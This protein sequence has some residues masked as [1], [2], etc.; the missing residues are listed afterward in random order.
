MQR[1]NLNM[2]PSKKSYASIVA[3]DLTDKTSLPLNPHLHHILLTELGITDIQAYK[4]A[5]S[6]PETLTYD[7]VFLDPDIKEW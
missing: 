7:Q 5:I 6:D 3:L 4:A 1:S 2:D